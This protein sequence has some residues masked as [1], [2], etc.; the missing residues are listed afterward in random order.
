MIFIKR[1][2]EIYVYLGVS[3][4]GL[5][6]QGGNLS[7]N[8]TNKENALKE[9]FEETFA[10]IYTNDIDE[11][12]SVIVNKQ[13]QLYPILIEIQDFNFFKEQLNK[14]KSI[15]RMLKGYN[16]FKE[17]TSYEIIPLKQ[18]FGTTFYM[19]E[20]KQ[21]I[22]IHRR[23]QASFLELMAQQIITQNFEVN[24]PIRI[25]E[26]QKVKNIPKLKRYDEL[27]DLIIYE[28]K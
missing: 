13:F 21:K 16:C 1:E 23:T 26:I 10:T 24:L 9:L 12:K 22:P 7:K 3:K 8:L 20:Q 4:R 11:T 6:E 5:E 25:A 2:N 19:N 15:I 14:N 17:M 18:V 28:I 27:R